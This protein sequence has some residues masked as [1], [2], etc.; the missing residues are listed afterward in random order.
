MVLS[1]RLL[2]DGIVSAFYRYHDALADL[3][4]AGEDTDLDG[5]YASFADKAMRIAMLLASVSNHGRIELRHWARTQI[6]ERWRAS[7]HHLI[8]QLG[9]S[10][11]SPER[12]LE[13]KLSRLFARH[14]T[15]TAREVGRNLHISAGEAERMREQ[16]VKGGVLYIEPGKRTKRY[17]SG[18]AT[19][20]PVTLS[21]VSHH[22]QDCDSTPEPFSLQ[23]EVS[24]EL[25]SSDRYDRVT[26]ATLPD[27]GDVTAWLPHRAE[28]LALGTA[29]A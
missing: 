19:V 5:S 20:T 13:D 17:R 1:D 12:I 11:D 6:A 23:Q 28:W 14:E 18:A 9:Q 24:Q 8:D 3:V 22:T 21:H 25:D 7:L 10:D 2:D 26:T 27:V 4:D 16:L 15:L 29:H